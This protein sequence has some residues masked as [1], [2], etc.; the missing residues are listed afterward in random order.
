LCSTA[1]ILSGSKLL[2]TFSTALEALRELEAK[3]YRGA[4]L[5]LRVFMPFPSR[6]VEKVLRSFDPERI[7]A[8]EHNY[9]GQAAKI[10]AMETGFKIRKF[11]LKWTGRPMYVMEVVEG[12][13]DILE[14][15]KS[16]VVLNYGK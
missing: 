6:A 11:I 1:I 7:I 14:K 9:L 2:S 3:G 16:R 5:H 15:G 10:I 13:L 8:V 12:V 4:Y